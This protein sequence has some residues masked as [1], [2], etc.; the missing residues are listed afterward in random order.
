MRHLSRFVVPAAL[1][2]AA[3]VASPTAEAA[4]GFTHQN[5]IQY[6][7]RG[8]DMAL[9]SGFS[10]VHQLPTFDVKTQG[11]VLQFDALETLA[12]LTRK[13]FTN[14][15]DEAMGLHFGA[16][17]YKTSLRKPIKGDKDGGDIVGVVQPGGQL[18]LDTNSG[19]S[20]MNA[21]VLGGVRMGAQASKGMGFGMYVVPQLGFASVRKLGGDKPDPTEST[22]GLAVGGQLQVSVW[23]K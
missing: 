21:A 4:W 9:D 18:T 6:E 7:T 14:D 2:T 1:V 11:W 8:F 19:F 23:V 22:I 13:E 15:G 20:H 10:S 12:S 5:T 3:A 17:V 16:G